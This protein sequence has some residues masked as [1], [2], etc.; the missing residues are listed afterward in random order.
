MRRAVVINNICFFHWCKGRDNFWNYQI[1]SHLFLNKMHFYY[2]LFF[3]VNGFHR[4]HWFFCLY[5]LMNRMN[6]MAGARQCLVKS[7]A[8]GDYLFS[9]SSVVSILN[10]R[11]R[12]KARKL[13]MIVAVVHLLFLRILRISVVFFINI[14]WTRWTGFNYLCNLCN[15]LTLCRPFRSSDLVPRLCRGGR[16]RCS[17]SS[18]TAAASKQKYLD[19]DMCFRRWSRTTAKAMPGA[20]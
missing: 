20:G 1:K 18:R 15:L 8:S 9:V 10:R 12:R 3:F 2:F 7:G 4:F 13:Y 5:H 6:L 16:F 11:Q 17:L 19:Y 14:G